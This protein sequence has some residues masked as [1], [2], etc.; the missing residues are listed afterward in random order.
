MPQ[1]KKVTEDDLNDD[2]LLKAYGFDESICHRCGLKN[3]EI[4]GLLLQCGKCKRAY[5]C[6]RDCFNKDLERHQQF[7]TTADLKKGPKSFSA[8]EPK[9]DDLG[10]D[11][12][13]HEEKPVEEDKNDVVAL[14][15]EE[16]EEE[17][18][19]VFDDEGDEGH[20]EEDVEDEDIGVI[21]EFLEGGN[22]DR[23]A[24]LSSRVT[25]FDEK[26]AQDEDATTAA[27]RKLRIGSGQ[28]PNS[29]RYEREVVNL[30]GAPTSPKRQYDWQKPEWALRSP[31]RKTE[32]GQVV[33]TSGNLAKP[34]TN[35]GTL[36]ESGEVEWSKPDWARNS[37]LKSSDRAEVIR[38]GGSLAK[39]VTKIDDLVQKGEFSWQKPEWVH[40]SPLKSATKT[41]SG[42]EAPLLAQTPV[43]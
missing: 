23:E 1:V 34:V 30:K 2:Q 21:E 39:P 11:L 25:K 15:T 26:N 9:K 3:S 40:K 20:E 42:Q 35:A 37:P 4:S 33:K 32:K 8:I 27:M 36:I 43:L 22:D 5:Y 10:A 7:C 29:P 14:N 16:E 12:A 6:G 28:L 17:E 24:D 41:I 13:L 31:L 19:L 18:E 38:S